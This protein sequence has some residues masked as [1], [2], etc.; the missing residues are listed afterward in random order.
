MT[1][2]TTDTEVN[3]LSHIGVV[4]M[5]WGHRKGSS[6]GGKSRTRVGSVRKAVSTLFAKK[7]APLDSIPDKEKKK[8]DADHERLV[9]I[10]KKN[11]LR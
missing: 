4:G 1:I 10:K 3:E 8:D 5:K 9:S 7:A 11:S 2:A 6:S